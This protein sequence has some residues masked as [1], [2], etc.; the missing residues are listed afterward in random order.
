[1]TKKNTKKKK[2][3]KKRIWWTLKRIPSWPSKVKWWIFHR[4]HPKHRYHMINTGLGY[5]WRDRDTV[6]EQLIVKILIDF[7]ELEKPYEHFNTETSHYRDN[8]VR[9]KEIYDFFKA[10]NHLDMK[11]DE[12]TPLLV[13]IVQLRKMLWT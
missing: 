7:V 4:F 12:L 1:M 11:Y 5:G 10:N 8:W 9:L 13:E 2:P 6:L 3:L